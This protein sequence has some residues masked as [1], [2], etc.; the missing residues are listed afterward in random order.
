MSYDIFQRIK[1]TKETIL[2][3][4][5]EFEPN[6]AV[7]AGSGL[8]EMYSHFVVRKVL[9]YSE[10]PYFHK[11]T[12]PGHTGEL[13]LCSYEDRDFLIFNGR[14]HYYEGHS[15]QDIIYPVRVMKFLGI[16]TLI[17]TAA[18]GA[19]NNKYNIGD[20]VVLNDHID[21]TGNSPLIGTNYEQFGER[22][23]NMESVY[24]KKLRAEALNAA[25]KLNIPA[26]EGVYFGV[27]GPAYETPASVKAYRILGGDVVGMSVVYEAT[28][29]AHMK[30][31]TLGLAYVS[32]MASGID[33]N[34]PNQEDVL[35]AGKRVSGNL[36]EI[37]KH[38]I[39]CP[40]VT[41]IS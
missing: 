28:A 21:F 10:I 6:I 41:A 14:F 15:P 31:N 22:F 12:A 29:A 5:A 26:K 17:L 38:I 7:I 39:L 16:K 4:L 27:S 8:G 18:V 19:L 23:P 20:I 33:N 30:L 25:A 32:N 37:I 1:E 36:A 3:S 40:A 11:T 2:S 9:K 34:T 13:L 35:K 24:S